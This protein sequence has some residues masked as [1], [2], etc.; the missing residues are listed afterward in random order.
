MLVIMTSYNAIKG[1]KNCP[2]KFYNNDYEDSNQRN[3]DTIRSETILIYYKI[4]INYNL[5]YK[6]IQLIFIAYFY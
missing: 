1:I 3:A 6:T 4:F 2:V 5:G